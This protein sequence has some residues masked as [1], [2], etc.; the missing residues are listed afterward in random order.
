MSNVAFQLIRNAFRRFQDRENYKR[1]FFASVALKLIPFNLSNEY[2]VAEEHA[3]CLK[4]YFTATPDPFLSIFEMRC[5]LYACLFAAD[6]LDVFEDYCQ[7]IEKSL[8]WC[9]VNLEPRKLS[10]LARSQVRENMNQCHLSLPVKVEKLCVPNTLRS[11]ILGDVFDI[12]HKRENVSTQQ[13]ITKSQ[14]AELHIG[15]PTL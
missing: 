8:P 13:P 6:K 1:I 14:L 5:V 12:S 2:S 10:E 9:P 15:R 3:S 7:E 11:F 4:M